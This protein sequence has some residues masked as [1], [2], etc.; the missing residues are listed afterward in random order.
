M[1]NCNTYKGISLL[2]SAYKTCAKIITGCSNVISEALLR[3]QEQHS[4]RKGRFCADC[5]FILKQIL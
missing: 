5:V 4:F 1:N 2:A 3:E